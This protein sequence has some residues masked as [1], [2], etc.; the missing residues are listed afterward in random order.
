MEEN[1]STYAL[2]D[3]I[4]NIDGTGMREGSLLQSLRNIPLPKSG[5]FITNKFLKSIVC[6]GDDLLLVNIM[7]TARIN[8]DLQDHA[9][10]HD[11]SKVY[12][13]ESDFWETS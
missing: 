6:D 5:S 2:A 3:K 1:E 4:K 10:Y 9:R 13:E 8:P 7:A 11:N 12:L